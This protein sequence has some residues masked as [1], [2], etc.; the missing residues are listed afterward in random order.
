VNYTLRF[1]TRAKKDAEKIKQSG[2]AETVS[3]L[4]DVLESNPYQN[5]PRFEK[6]QPPHANKYSR[7]INKQHRLVYTIDA[8]TR[9]VDV[10]S[11]WTH[12]EK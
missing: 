11:M 6:L 3:K 12:Y 10:Q 2:L 5:P 7:R 1:T 4:L 9:I 8:Q